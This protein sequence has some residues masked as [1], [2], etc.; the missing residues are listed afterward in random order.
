[1]TYY[2]LPKRHMHT[3]PTVTST[4]QYILKHPIYQVQLHD[5]HRLH[6][7]LRG[8]IVA[9]QV[10]SLD[11]SEP[12]LRDS[13]LRHI[14]GGCSCFGAGD[15]VES[16]LICPVTT[17][18]CWLPHSGGEKE[19]HLLGDKGLY[20]GRGAKATERRQSKAMNSNER[21]CWS[22]IY[23]GMSSRVTDT[24]CQ[25]RKEQSDSGKRRAVTSGSKPASKPEPE[26]TPNAAPAKQCKQ[27]PA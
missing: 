14:L 19:V 13:E 11:Q 21:D 1:M 26:P 10:G 6:S 16:S 27:G 4:P 12:V 8:V 2:C 9:L 17:G 23:G 24:T 5:L 18:L 7:A 22:S 20:E 25:Q 15:D 3:F